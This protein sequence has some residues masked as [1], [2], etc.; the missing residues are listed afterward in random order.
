MSQQEARLRQKLN[1]WQELS[2]S[3]DELIELARLNDASLSSELES[4]TLALQ[5]RLEELKQE[6]RFNGPYDDHDVIM[7]I[8]AGAGGK[9]AESWTQMLQRMYTRWAEERGIKADVVDLSRGEDQGIK[10]V[11]LKLTGSDYLYGKLHGEH[12]V[13]RMV[14]KSPFNSAHS[15]ETS[16][17]R[18][19][20][21][22]VIDEPGELEIDDKDLDIKVSRSSGPGGQSVNTTDSAVRIKHIPSGI[23]VSIQNERSQL[24][25]KETAMAILRSRLAQLQEEQ[26]AE[27]LA[28]IKGPTQAAEFGNRIRDYV[29]DDRRVKDDRTGY[30]TTDTDGVLNGNLD[31]IIEAWLENTTAS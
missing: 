19:D 2:K 4:Q 28:D 10:N 26:H 31:P 8:K 11:T 15:R 3:I 21:L 27:K 22:P 14:R 30:E 20:I 18:V 13:H 24:Q 9:D 6:L 29:L 7:S 25:N 23:E 5:A 1:N 12:G 17:A 16:F